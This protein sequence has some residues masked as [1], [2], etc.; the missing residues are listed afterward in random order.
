MYVGNLLYTVLPPSSYAIA[1]QGEEEA[2]GRGI[3][4][5]SVCMKAKGTQTKFPS[6]I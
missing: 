1:G 2:F 5:A 4:W 6:I 3:P